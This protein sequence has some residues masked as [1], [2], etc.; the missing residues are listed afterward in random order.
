MKTPTTRPHKVSPPRG[1]HEGVG[2]AWVAERETER[3][4]LAPSQ[5]D[6]AVTK[7]RSRRPQEQSG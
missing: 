4:D 6:D 2:P 1:F 7:P 3:L 5:T